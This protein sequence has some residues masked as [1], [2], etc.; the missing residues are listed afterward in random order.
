MQ[1]GIM[2]M[3]RRI[4]LMNTPQYLTMRRE[5]LKNDRIATPSANEYDLTLWDTTKNTDWQQELLGGTAHYSK[6]TIGTSGSNRSLQYLVSSTYQKQ[7]TVYPGDYN[8]QKSSVFFN[9]GQ[10]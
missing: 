1:Q 9:L 4:D 7:T 5:A 10:Q 2:Q 6:Y 8:D 3:T